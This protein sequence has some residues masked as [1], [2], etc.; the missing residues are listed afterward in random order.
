M[1]PDG[2]YFITFVKEYEPPYILDKNGR[3]ITIDLLN[4]NTGR[5]YKEMNGENILKHI[6]INL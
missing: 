4:K 2:I 5:V 1:V 6:F 3:D